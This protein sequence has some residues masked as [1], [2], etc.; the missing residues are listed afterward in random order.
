MS[1]F[2]KVHGAMSGELWTRGTFRF[3]NFAELTPSRLHGHLV[4]PL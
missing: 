4:T 2:F 1:C 3:A